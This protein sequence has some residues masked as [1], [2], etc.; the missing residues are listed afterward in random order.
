MTSTS[1][2]RTFST[3]SGV[4]G[5]LE[6]DGDLPPAQ[7]S[8]VSLSPRGCRRDAPSAAPVDDAAARDDSGRPQEAG[9]PHRPGST[10]P[11]RSHRPGR[12]L[13]GARKR[14]TW[15]T[16]AHSPPS[17]AVGDGEVGD[18]EHSVAL[19]PPWTAVPAVL[20]L[21][22]HACRQPL[23]SPYPNQL[24]AGAYGGPPVCPGANSRQ[25]RWPA[26]RP[27][28]TTSDHRGRV[29]GLHSCSSPPLGPASS[30]RRGLPISLY[31]SSQHQ[32][33]A[34]QATARPGD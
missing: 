25:P 1:W 10:C 29:D 17:V 9:T 33:R 11:T 3:G 34:D 2:S 16:A 13:A 20:R 28:P 31:R 30:R 5:A 18:L 12:P 8:G 26:R 27:G 15:S 4:H 14:L 21:K 23:S 32:A 6:D 22:P 19:A 24:W 7:G